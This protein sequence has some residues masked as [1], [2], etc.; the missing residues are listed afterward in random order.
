M[1]TWENESI[2]GS[3]DEERSEEDTPPETI[4]E[5]HRSLSL[6]LFL[7]VSWAVWVKSIELWDKR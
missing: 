4:S 2:P 7:S 3:A 1:Y 6:S 5:S